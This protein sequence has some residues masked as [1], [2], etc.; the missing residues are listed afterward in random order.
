LQTT[1]ASRRRPIE[2]ARFALAGA[3]AL[4][5]SRSLAQGAPRLELTPYVG[6]GVGGAFEDEESTTKIELDD[7]GAFGLA[8]NIRES[9]NTQWE[10]I[11]AQQDTS[12]DTSDLT[13]F[14][15]STDLRV[16][17]LHGGGTY[18][19]DSRGTVQP[20]LVATVGGTHL[21]PAAPG[22]DS[23]TFWS[24]SIGTGL[25]IGMTERLAARLEARAWGTLVESGS[26]LFCVSGVG[27]AACL[28]EIDGKVL[29]QVELFAGLTM[30]F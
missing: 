24:F 22:L 2:L 29:Y 16:Q 5:A 30:R 26:S 8:F 11:Y 28:I 3:L 25:R 15:P 27:G 18:E 6:Y 12:A 23:D 13:G 4:A 17:Y 14:D 9:G 19:F 10:V 20:Y 1:R 21:S 7:G